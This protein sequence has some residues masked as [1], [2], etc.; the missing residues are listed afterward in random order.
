MYNT[1]VG[2]GAVGARAAS[3]YGS[4]SGSD[5]KMR[6]LAALAPKHWQKLLCVLKIIVKPNFSSI[7]EPELQEVL[8]FKWN[9]NSIA[10]RLR[11]LAF[12]TI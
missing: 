9:R 6:L 2:A 10:M 11:H 3:R 5:Q 7:A 1:I 12:F 4:S 8:S